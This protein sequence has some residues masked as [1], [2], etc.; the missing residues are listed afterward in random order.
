MHNRHAWTEK[1]EEGTKREVRVVK[2]GGTWRFQSKSSDEMNW[3]YY[4]EPL[5][6]D[7]E[8]FRQ[9]LLRKYQRRRASY[10]DVLWAEH[11]LTRLRNR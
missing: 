10:E 11:E 7:L 4:D 8:Q 5:L 1:N 9:V 3:T 6:D 2:S